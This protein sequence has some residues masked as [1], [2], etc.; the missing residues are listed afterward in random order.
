MVDLRAASAPVVSAIIVQEPCDLWM[1]PPLF[2]SGMTLLSVHEGTSGFGA[3][4]T[5]TFP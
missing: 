5:P 1:R 3:K 2:N 4:R